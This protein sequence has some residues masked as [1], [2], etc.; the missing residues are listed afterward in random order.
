VSWYIRTRKE[1]GFN[2][3]QCG[4]N[5]SCFEQDGTPIES[6]LE[7]IDRV[8]D[9]AEAEGMMIYLCSQRHRYV[10][11]KPVEWIGDD[12]AAQSAGR[13]YAARYAGRKCVMAFWISGLDDRYSPDYLM[14]LAQGVRDGAPNHLIGWHPMHG[15][16][17][18]GDAANP[19]VPIGPLCN[20][21]TAQSGHRN[22]S[23]GNVQS[24]I[25]QCPEDVPFWD[26]EPCYEGMPQYGNASHI[27]DATD[28]A[29]AV[30]TAVK[31]KKTAA[32]GYGHHLGWGFAPGWQA[33]VKNAPGWRKVI[34]AAQAI[35]E[36]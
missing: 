11:G 13:I 14:P 31:S 17:S 24:L 18:Y 22:L 25:A 35:Q 15:C 29:R 19:T 32:V 7:T 12:A 26:V 9:T 30:G 16:T 4:D 23:A 21:V 34:E 2:V 36:Q 6:R 5:G 27:I 8:L 33:A 28:V 3:I 1:Q 20:F 10:S